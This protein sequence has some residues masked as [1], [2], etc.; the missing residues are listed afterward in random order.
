[1]LV[2]CILHANAIV[3]SDRAGVVADAARD[4]GGLTKPLDG[5]PR[6]PAF[7]SEPREPV[8]AAHLLERICGVAHASLEEPPKECRVAERR[9]HVL[10]EIE[11]GPGDVGIF[12]QRARLRGAARALAVRG[13]DMRELSACR[14]CLF[15]RAGVSEVVLEQVAELGPPLHLGVEADERAVRFAI[16]RIVEYCLAECDDCRLQIQQLEPLDR[17]DAV[18]EVAPPRRIGAALERRAIEHDA[19]LGVALLL[20]QLVDL[21]DQLGRRR[22]VRERRAI[23]RQRRGDLA[24]CIRLLPDE[25]RQ[26]EE[27]RRVDRAISERR[28]QQRGASGRVGGRPN[29]REA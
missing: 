25:H 20:E 5:L 7:L 24:G 1:M 23:R 8:E 29:A 27:I 15:C 3:E 16:G 12:E 11:L 9:G 2:V 14:T 21:G 28:A 13:R 26:S 17:A 4:V 10:D 6:V 18:E 19:L 22:L